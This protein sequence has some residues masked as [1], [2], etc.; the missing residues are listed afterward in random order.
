MKAYTI[1]AYGPA[2]PQSGR[3]VRV[4]VGSEDKVR[5]QLSPCMIDFI[6]IHAENKKAALQI[7]EIYTRTLNKKQH[8]GKP[9]YKLLR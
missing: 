3:F 9:P 5:D 2:Y 4:H 7:A 6:E 1:E 8:S